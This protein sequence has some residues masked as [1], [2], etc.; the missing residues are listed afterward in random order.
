MIGQLHMLSRRQCVCVLSR[1]LFVGLFLCVSSVGAMD[2]NQASSAELQ[3]LPGIGSKTAE[4]II[5]ERERGGA[6][7]SLEDL[8][9]RVKGIGPKKREALQE[10]GLMVQDPDGSLDSETQ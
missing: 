7:T 5:E 1:V 6:F 10:A 9:D 2:V 3:T 8:S 4:A